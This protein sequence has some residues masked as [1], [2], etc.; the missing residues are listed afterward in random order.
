MTARVLLI[1]AAI[2]VSLFAIYFMGWCAGSRDMALEISKALRSI[3]LD[4]EDL[5]GR[6]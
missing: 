2:C 3:G 5:D 4:L 6:R 1:F